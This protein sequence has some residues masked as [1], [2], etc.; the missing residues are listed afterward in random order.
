[1]KN[2]IKCEESSHGHIFRMLVINSDTSD[3][4][5][6]ALPSNFDPYD[7]DDSDDQLRARQNMKQVKT[8]LEKNGKLVKEVGSKYV[9]KPTKFAASTTSKIF[10]FTLKLATIVTVLYLAYVI[11]NLL[12]LSYK[13]KKLAG[14][15]SEVK[16]DSEKIDSEVY[17]DEFENPIVKMSIKELENFVDAQLWCIIKGKWNEFDREFAAPY[18]KKCQQMLDIKPNLDVHIRGRHIY[19]DRENSV[20]SIRSIGL[21]PN[22]YVKLSE[23]PY[24]PKLDD[25]ILYLTPEFKQHHAYMKQKQIDQKLEDIIDPLDP[26]TYQWIDRHE[27]INKRKREKTSY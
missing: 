1:M 4:K 8:K 18:I 2:N 25:I 10:S 21:N 17:D 11:G 5:R 22:Q 6:S 12:Y 26:R 24:F 3:F 7:L 15:V 19:T 13:K 14:K 27:S 20:S 16:K 23:V 9:V